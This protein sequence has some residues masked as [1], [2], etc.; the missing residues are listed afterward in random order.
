VWPQLFGGLDGEAKGG[1]EDCQPLA[2][3]TNATTLRATR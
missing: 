2:E 1:L 3:E